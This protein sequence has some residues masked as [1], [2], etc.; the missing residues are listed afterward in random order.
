M[1]TRWCKSLLAAQQL[2]NS[3]ETCLR[4]DNHHSPVRVGPPV[5]HGLYKTAKCRD[6]TGLSVGAP[7]LLRR[8]LNA[9]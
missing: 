2:L 5:A 9:P 7:R 6:A 1:G 8:G 3:L 4:N